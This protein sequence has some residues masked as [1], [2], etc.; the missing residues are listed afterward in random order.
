MELTSYLVIG[1]AVSL[2][3]QYLKL[4]MKT[5]KTGTLAIVLG[6]SIL[7]GTV[8]FLVRET[9]L[10]EPI[11]SILAFSGAIYTYIIKQFEKE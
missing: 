7:A 8:Y 10:W 2:L 11:V 4:K 6:I 5:N 9:S 1:V 3:V